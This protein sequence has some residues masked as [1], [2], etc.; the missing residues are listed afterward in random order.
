MV[1]RTMSRKSKAGRT[2]GP[3]RVGALVLVGAAVIL[4]LSFT[5][6]GFPGFK[7][8]LPDSGR[9]FDCRTC[10]TGTGGSLNPFGTDFKENGETYSSALAA[11]DSDGDGYTNDEEFRADPVTN[12]GDATS[13]PGGEVP[14]PPEPEELD[15][16]PWILTSF[17]GI[18]LIL[19]VAVALVLI[20]TSGKPGKEGGK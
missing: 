5:A 10:H 8:Q 15:L 4:A 17:A 16:F 11:M 14:P 19:N 3:G 12:P 6:S 13:H 9:T 7:S 1:V 18:V 20:A 2:A